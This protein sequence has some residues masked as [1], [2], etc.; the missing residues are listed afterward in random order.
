MIEKNL[1]LKYIDLTNAKEK[2]SSIESCLSEFIDN[3]ISSFNEDPSRWHE[4]LNINIVYYWNNGNP[5]FEIQDNANGINNEQLDKCMDRYKFVET[6]KSNSLNQYGIG[7]K[8]GI[9]WL[10]EDGLILTKQKNNCFYKGDYNVLSIND[11]NAD[12]KITVSDNL[13]ENDIKYLNQNEFNEFNSGTKIIIKNIHNTTERKITTEKINQIKNF[14]GY[15]FSNYLSKNTNENKFK[16]NILLKIC[17]KNGVE[18]YIIKPESI[19]QKQEKTFS[20]SK[21]VNDPTIINSLKNEKI[22]KYKN[23]KYF[24]FFEPY[25]NDLFND[26]KMEYLNYE[27]EFI[28]SKNQIKFPI[29]WKIM[30][31]ANSE[32]SGICIKHKNRYIQHPTF[33]KNSIIKLFPWCDNDRSFDYKKWLHA[34]IDISELPYNENIQFIKPDEHK[35]SLKDVILNNDE[36]DNGIN[37]SNLKLSFSQ[38]LNKIYPILE[39]IVELK[40]NKDEYKK[41]ENE[42]KKDIKE[43]EDF[44]LIEKNVITTKENIISLNLAN[45]KIE[46]HTINDE[47]DWILRK[48]DIDSNIYLFNEQSKLIS[49][50]STTSKILIYFIFYVE[51]YIKNKNNNYETKNLDSVNTL[52][53]RI[54]KN[55]N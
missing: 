4:E 5:Y 23:H 12:V 32:L 47:G 37:L 42:N 27:I 30:N 43:I 21:F 15:R 20:I 22:E 38:F 55:N 10:G 25:L 36:D 29:K 17:N 41:K 13:N 34:E 39:I 45:E 40:S 28:N 8:F 6:E 2:N 24:N 9:F 35:I 54:I 51:Q 14:L 53:N 48:K 44:G 1:K 26:K 19:F 18:S 49:K 7:M 31:E 16:L 11:M 3:S 50:N 52:I 46:I 33:N